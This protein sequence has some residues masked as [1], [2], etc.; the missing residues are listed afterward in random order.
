MHCSKTNITKNK[1]SFIFCKITNN[2]YDKSLRYHKMHESMLWYCNIPCLSFLPQF[3][4]KKRVIKV[5]VH[6]CH[7]ENKNPKKDLFFLFWFKD[8]RTAA[9][10]TLFTDSNEFIEHS[11]TK[12]EWIKFQSTYWYK[13]RNIG[14]WIKYSSSDN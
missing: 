13:L 8:A 3:S 9:S 12:N 2:K 1:L 6:F 7:F 14:F 4:T 10:N 5:C 11:A